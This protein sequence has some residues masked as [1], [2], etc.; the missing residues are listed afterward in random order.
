MRKAY[1]AKYLTATT[2]SLHTDA[3]LTSSP[4]AIGAGGVTGTV[5]LAVLG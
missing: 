2:L 3:A 4:V 5:K 1:Y